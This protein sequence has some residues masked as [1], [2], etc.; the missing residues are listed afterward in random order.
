MNATAALIRRTP[1]EGWIARR[2][3]V[4]GPTLTREA[5]AHHQLKA[6]Q[7]TVA[8]A[9]THSAFYAD[10][11]SAL[12]A[13]IP[14]S[15]HDISRLPFT[16]PE[17]L[18][19]HGPELLC[20]SQDEIRRVVTLHSSGTTGTP[21]R[22]FFTAADQESA[23]DFFANGVTAIAAPGDRMLIALPS[24]REGSVGYQL[25]KGIARAGIIP[26]PHGLSVDPKPTLAHLE[27]EHATCIIG[28]PV[29]MLAL[30][31]NDSPLARRAL[32]LLRSIVLCSDHVPESLV[33]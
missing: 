31:M 14:G 2:L 30:A 13:D 25:A 19:H 6:L 3:A 4:S 26:I 12:P 32:R 29:Q 15:L 11:L 18:V 20:V 23:L 5:I 21:K 8:W 28:L 17:D 7:K 24:E 10:R 1:L 9:R 27:R 33:R 16:Y 22:L